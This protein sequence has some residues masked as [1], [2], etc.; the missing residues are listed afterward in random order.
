MFQKLQLYIP[1]LEIYNV[2]QHIKDPEK[3]C[4]KSYHLTLCSMFI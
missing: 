3:F 2:Y 4:G 1:S